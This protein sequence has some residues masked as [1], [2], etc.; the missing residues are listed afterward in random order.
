MQQA[1]PK[2]QW[3]K[4]TQIYYKVLYGLSHLLRIAVLPVMAQLYRILQ[5]CD[6]IFSSAFK[7]AE[8]ERLGLY[9][10]KCFCLQIT[11]AT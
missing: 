5:F 10:C 9:E 3:L 11:H 1:I 7:S 6:T 4:V 8:E 2:S